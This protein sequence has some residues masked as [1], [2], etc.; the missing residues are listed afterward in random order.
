ME[1]IH[2]NLIILGESLGNVA[3]K[4]YLVT[5]LISLRYCHFLYLKKSY[6]T[7]AF[8]KEALFQIRAILILWLSLLILLLFYK[9]KEYEASCALACQVDRNIVFQL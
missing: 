2:N 7:R 3:Q 8:C 9:I 6:S 1:H 5:L 4:L